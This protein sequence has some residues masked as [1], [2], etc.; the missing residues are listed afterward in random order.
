MTGQYFKDLLII[1]ECVKN[2]VLNIL[3]ITVSIGIVRQNTGAPNSLAM[4]MLG[5]LFNK[6]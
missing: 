1:L 6:S 3:I 4:V 2:D 5:A